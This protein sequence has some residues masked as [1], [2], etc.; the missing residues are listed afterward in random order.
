MTALVAETQWTMTKIV[1][2][3]N[4][5]TLYDIFQ[6]NIFLLHTTSVYLQV[7]WKKRKSKSAIVKVREYSKVVWKK[8]AIAKVRE[9]SKVVWK[10]VQLPRWEKKWGKSTIQDIL[11]RG[12]GHLMK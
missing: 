10:K 6:I 9:Y 12:R 5:T 3:G 1:K 8:G 4:R 2:L 11:S 7:V